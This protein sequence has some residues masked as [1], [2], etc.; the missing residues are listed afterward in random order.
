[1]AHM[2]IFKS[3][4]AH[5]NL[6]V[7]PQMAA[8]MKNHFPFLGISSPLRKELSKSFLHEKR[9]LKSIDWDFVYECFEQ[10]EREYQYLALDYLISMKKYVEITDIEH[11]ENLIKT[12]KL[13]GFCGFSRSNCRCFGDEIP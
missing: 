12:K 3:L 2:E 11:I 7:A 13:V 5:K 8:Y 10:A 1:M 9:K 4:K 6:E